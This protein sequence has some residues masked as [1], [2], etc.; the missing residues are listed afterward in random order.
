MQ[1]KLVRTRMIGGGNSYKAYVP[2]SCF[3]PS[4]KI[5]ISQ[6]Y[7]N[8]ECYHPLRY[9]VLYLDKQWITLEPSFE[10]YER[11]QELEPVG[12]HVERSLYWD[13]FP[14]TRS[15]E[16]FTLWV[17]YSEGD[18]PSTELSVDVD[19]ETIISQAKSSLLV[20]AIRG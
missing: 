17:N 14:E 8:G 4:R 10:R 12:K 9:V 20:D 15:K 16:D 5:V 2:V 13:Y 19:L 7:R 6:T 1:V 11:L 3:H 18:Y